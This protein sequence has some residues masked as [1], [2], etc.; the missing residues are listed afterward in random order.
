[1]QLCSPFSSST[2]TSHS[3]HVSTDYFYK[4]FQL[5][6]HKHKQVIGPLSAG[7]DLEQGTKQA[8]PWMNSDISLDK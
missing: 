8:Y 5:V 7:I 1:M 4:F 2:S 3:D 6:V